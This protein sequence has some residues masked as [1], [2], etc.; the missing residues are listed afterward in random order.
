MNKV[1]LIGNITKKPE[2][3][4]TSSGISYTSFTLAVNRNYTKEDGSRDTDFINCV[5]WRNLADTIYKYCDK[6]SRI[7]VEGKLQT[8]SYDSQN[9]SKKYVT[10]VLAESIEFLSTKKAEATPEIN[11]EVNPYEAIGNEIEINDADLPF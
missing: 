9:G 10:E 3:R 1:I 11:T 4:V 7:S 5:S 2:N 8:R 6:G